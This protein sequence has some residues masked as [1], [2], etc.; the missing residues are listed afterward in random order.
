MCFFLMFLYG[1]P[2][3]QCF[4]E[5]KQNTPKTIRK[6]KRLTEDEYIYGS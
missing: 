2:V 6:A 3:Y 4:A 5:S 1:V